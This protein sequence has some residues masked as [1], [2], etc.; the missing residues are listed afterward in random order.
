[1]AD[2]A[3]R[4]HAHDLAGHGPVLSVVA[5]ERREPAWSKAR[6]AGFAELAY[7]TVEVQ[8]CDCAPAP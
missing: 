3:A 6:L 2:R 7:V 1:M 8:R 4:R 5:A